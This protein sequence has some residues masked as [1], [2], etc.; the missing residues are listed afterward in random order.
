VV[1]RVPPLTQRRLHSY[2]GMVMSGV[3]DRLAERIAALVNRV[4]STQ[5]DGK[6]IAKKDK[7]EDMPGFIRVGLGGYFL[8]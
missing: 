1:E 5:P 4:V 7:I 3:A 6:F 2:A 8:A